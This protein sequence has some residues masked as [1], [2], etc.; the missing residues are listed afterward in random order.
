MNEINT[1]A[2]IK[3]MKFF[4][5]LF[6]YFSAFIPLFVLLV[7]KLLV[8][9]FNNNLTFNFLNTFNLVLLFLMISLGIVGILWNTVF[10]KEAVIEITIKNAE[11]I[12]DKYFLPYFSLF[13]MFA[14]PLDI[15]YFNE[16]FV[17]VIILIFI[18]IVYINC[19]LFY[20]NPLLNIMGFRFFDTT[21]VDKEGQ[22]QKAKI[23]C[24][25]QLNVDSTCFVK[26]KNQH[27]AFISKNKL[28]LKKHNQKYN[29]NK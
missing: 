13:V 19:G 21:Y 18:G 25:N 23:F 10:S 22:I 4:N 15:S 9:I 6:L 27:F 8:D 24:K 5:N 7:V 11:E 16:F 2:Q 29:N 17:Y 28:N 3:T 1:T 20:I 14:I 12:T 26:I